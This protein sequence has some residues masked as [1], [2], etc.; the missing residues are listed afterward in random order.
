MK[1]YYLRIIGFTVEIFTMKWAEMFL[2][3]LAKY[4]HRYIKTIFYSSIANIFRVIA[5]M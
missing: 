2:A 3:I 1:C 5:K 4:K